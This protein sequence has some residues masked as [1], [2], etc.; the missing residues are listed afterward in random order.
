MAGC[1]LGVGRA[2]MAIAVGTGLRTGQRT[3]LLR[4]CGCGEADL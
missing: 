4:V 2:G 3:G 1:G